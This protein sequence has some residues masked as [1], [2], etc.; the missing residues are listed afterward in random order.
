MNKQSK[1]RWFAIAVAAATIAVSTGCQNANTSTAERLHGEKFDEDDAPRASRNAVAITAANGARADATLY[2]AHFNSAGLN[3]LGRQKLD[4]MMLDDESTPPMTVYLDLGKNEASVKLA[5]TA[6]A[7]Y[8]KARG[9]ADN[10]FKVE[11]GPNPKTIHPAEDGITAVDALNKTTTA[12]Q[13]GG[14][15]AGTTTGGYSGSNQTS[16]TPMTK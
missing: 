1:A 10:Q 15:P 14:Q 4:L 8:L 6:V 16:P 5:H 7:E 9:V 2:P 12:N 11:D 3:S 13:P